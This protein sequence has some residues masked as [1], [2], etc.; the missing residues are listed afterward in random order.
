VSFR[1]PALLA[2]LALVPLAIAAYVLAQ[3]RGRAYAVRYT[4]VDLLASVAGRQRT[5]HL[6]A[7][8]ALVALTALALAVARPQHTVAAE[9]RE[10]TVMLVTDTSDSMLAEDVRPS[11]L[12]AAKRAVRDF[13]R[14]VP[15]D[16]RVG[17][18][19]FSQTAETLVSPTTDREALRLALDTIATRRGTAL[20]D[21][22]RLGLDLARTPI[23]DGLGGNRRLPAAIVL[24][25]D[26]TQTHGTSDPL[27]LA[28]QAKRARVPIHTV[29]LGQPDG[30]LVRP[31]GSS[32]PV[33]PDPTALRRIASESGGRFFATADAR[34]L[35]QIYEN[36]GTALAKREEQRE[37]TAAFAGGALAFLLAGAMLG[38]V[39]AGRLP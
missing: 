6:P 9:R 26:G 18:V 24:L 30:V 34:Q 23:S 8:L 38:L 2:A 25:S 10:A 20:G 5:R 28:R 32:E 7:A 13:G 11:R 1:E 31:D 35:R 27:A 4:N 21:G 33:P 16:F 12:A 3:R 17:L 37:L 29:A 39:R 36:L 22:L 19:G 15:E 14:Q